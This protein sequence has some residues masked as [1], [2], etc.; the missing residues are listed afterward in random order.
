MN[1][2]AR[3][4]AAGEG[5]ASILRAYTCGE[6]AKQSPVEESEEPTFNRGVFYS[7]LEA[8]DVSNVW[9]S[10]ASMDWMPLRLS[11]LRGDF[12]S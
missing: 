5:D 12:F 3:S 8:S 4:A 7:R 1:G 2:G 11:R 9:G 10:R 6:S